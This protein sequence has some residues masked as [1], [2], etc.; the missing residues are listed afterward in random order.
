MSTGVEVPKRTGAGRR[1][2]RIAARPRPPS[3]PPFVP[4]T[5]EYELGEVKPG[6]SL[7][8][9]TV[10]SARASVVDL[11]RDGGSGSD[12]DVAR[13]IR[14]THAHAEEREVQALPPVDEGRDA[15]SFLIAATLVETIV[16]G[17]PWSVGVL[18]QYWS[19]TMF[20]DDE[21]TLTLAATLQTGLMYMT[22]AFL[23]P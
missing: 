19:A 4:S 23:G 1:P 14:S 22:A 3:P 20:P 17:L 8:P 21:S 7:P 10:A 5:N 18:H 15:W 9:S 2:S 12:E 16:W 11:E 6:P 13:S